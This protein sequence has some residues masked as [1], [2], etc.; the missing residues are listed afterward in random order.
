MQK[1]KGKNIMRKYMTVLLATVLS[2]C[3][4]IDF[5]AGEDGAV[6]YEPVPYL[7]YAVTDKCVSSA[8]AVTLPGEKRH[9]DFKAGYGSSS[10]SAEFANGLLTKVGQ[11]SDSNISETLT[12][13]GT[14]GIIKSEESSACDPKAVLYPIENGVPNLN[15]PL[16]LNLGR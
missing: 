5:N 11:T 9:L 8:T 6:Y 1:I 13:I 3:A 12:S 7:F 14:A 15:E 4:S 10:L 16:D 2:G